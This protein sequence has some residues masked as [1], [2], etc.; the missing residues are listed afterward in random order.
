MYATFIASDFTCVYYTAAG[1]IFGTTDVY[2]LSFSYLSISIIKRNGPLCYKTLPN[3][4]EPIDLSH[5]T[6]KHPVAWKTTLK[7]WSQMTV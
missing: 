4:L 3:P 2:E 5:F 1:T 6:S 7:I